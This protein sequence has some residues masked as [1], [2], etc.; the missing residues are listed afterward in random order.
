MK[1]YYIPTTS[2]NFNNILSSESISPKSFYEK[3]SFGYS[4]WFLTK[5]NALQ[6][7][8]VL[9]GEPRSF[10]MPESEQEDHPL[11]IEIETFEQ[12]EQIKPGI[13]LSKKTIQL[14]P[15]TTRFIFFSENDKK[16]TLSMS[17]SSLETK[18]TKPYLRRMSVENYDAS[19]EL[20]SCN[21][22]KF[23]QDDE[24]KKDRISNKLKGLL[25]G[26]YIG[27]ILS[28]SPENAKKAAVFDEIK[29]ILSAILAASEHVPSDSQHERLKITFK[30]LLNFEPWFKELSARIDE[31][32]IEF[33]LKILKKHRVL[34]YTDLDDVL[35]MLRSGFSSESNPA[36]VWVREE[37]AKLER[38]IIQQQQ[39]LDTRAD[40]IIV[41]DGMLKQ[42]KNPFLSKET[43]ISLF[44]MLINDIFLSEKYNGKI[45]SFRVEL[46]DEIT[47]KVKDFFGNKWDDSCKERSFLNQLRRHLRGEEFNQPWNNGLLSSIAAVLIRGDDWDKLLKFMQ[48]KGMNDYKLAFSLYGALHGFANLTRDFTDILLCKSQ[49]YVDDVIKEFSGQLFK[50]DVNDVAIEP[51]SNIAVIDANK[52][53]KADNKKTEK[54][55]ANSKKENTK[56][57]IYAERKVAKKIAKPRKKQTTNTNELELFPKSFLEESPDCLVSYLPDDPNLKNKIKENIRYFQRQYNDENGYYKRKPEYKR[58]N[59]EVID[60][61]V[62]CCFSEKSLIPHKFFGKENAAILDKFKETLLTIYHD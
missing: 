21:E 18:M 9:Y 34:R 59:S 13:F 60:H 31:K 61:F 47:Q 2:L 54:V 42:I 49:T 48:S 17:D 29:N 39:S 38:I 37:I 41:Q 44:I 27:A 43:D 12:Y 53:G 52:P 36:F 32:S 11:L 40:E 33:T 16:I 58:N 56:Q 24:I 6:N 51:D 26:Y 30:E 50:V 55:R 15:K 14:S 57:N 35:L 10:S 45:S 25:Y 7:A 4:R 3:R 8:I 19:Y 62:K 23:L 5:E 28:M 20:V 46:S 22:D 1:K